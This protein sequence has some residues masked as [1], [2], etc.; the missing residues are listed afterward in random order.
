MLY[1]AATAIP[2]GVRGCRSYLRGQRF[3]LCFMH[4]AKLGWCL[5][6]A[7]K[8]GSREHTCQLV[9]PQRHLDSGTDG[10]INNLLCPRRQEYVLLAVEGVSGD[11][12]VY[13]CMVPY[14]H[15]AQLYKTSYFVGYDA[16]DYKHQLLASQRVGRSY[17]RRRNNTKNNKVIGGGLFMPHPWHRYR[18]QSS[19]Y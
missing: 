19:I 7:I 14:N 11:I 8:Y 13:K 12:Y 9:V 10:W 2:Y 4:V 1:V 15:N 18:E 5:I 6:R 16:R 17:T 3:A